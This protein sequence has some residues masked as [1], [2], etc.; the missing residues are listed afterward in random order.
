MRPVWLN[1]SLVC[2]PAIAMLTSPL[3][4]STFNTNRLDPNQ[5]NCA[6]MI[7][8]PVSLPLPSWQPQC[9][10]PLKPLLLA[11]GSGWLTPPRAPAVTL[12]ATHPASPRPLRLVH[13]KSATLPAHQDG[14]PLTNPRTRSSWISSKEMISEKPLNNSTGTSSTSWPSLGLTLIDQWIQKYD[15]EKYHEKYFKN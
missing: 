15:Y 4:A 14:D 6:A 12:T 9:A 5:D 7:G 3:V 8:L 2:A 1:A 13:G 10:L 11:C